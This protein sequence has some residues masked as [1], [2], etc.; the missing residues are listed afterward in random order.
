MPEQIST[1]Y[2][3]GMNLTDRIANDLQSSGFDLSNLRPSDFEPIDEF[4]FR[5]RAATVQ[6]LEQMKLAPGNHVLDIGSGLGG[7]ARTIAE[8][9][10]A[11][12]VGV[13][14]TP[15]FCEAAN[16]ISN[17]VDLGDK[18]DFLQGDATDLPFPDNQFD[19][20]VTVHVAMNIPNKL[21]MYQ[22]AHRVLK[23]GARFGIYDIVQ[24][25]GGDVLYPAPWA[26]D[27]SISQLATPAE[28]SNY[29]LQAGF[30]ILHEEDSTAESFNWLKERATQPKPTRSLPVTTQLLFGDTAAEMTQ[31]QL[32][33]LRERRMLT[34]C[35]ICE[36]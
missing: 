13:D 17:W 18:T 36:A 3:R 22:E 15:E 9:A 5:G 25:E 16:A 10:N 2:G 34:Y 11:S 28:M 24:G 23:P 4:H 21:A 29:L 6:L 14:L 7:V 30:R 1:H 20:A 27:A 32:L 26:T 19:G 8:E 31:N 33:G 35:F 12:V